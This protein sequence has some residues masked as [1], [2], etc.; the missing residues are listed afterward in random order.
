LFIG[1]LAVFLV[2][3]QLGELD[4]LKCSLASSGRKIDPGKSAPQWPTEEEEK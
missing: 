3:V 1:N 2:K 4:P